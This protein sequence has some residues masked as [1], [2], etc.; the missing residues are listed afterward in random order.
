MLE[1]STLINWFA[2]YAYEPWMVYA[3][4]L[5]L[6][7]ASSFGLPLPEEVTL[8]SAGFLAYFSL[9]PELYPPPYEGA[10]SVRV[11]SLAAFCFF[12]VMFSDLLVF[13]IGKFGGTRVFQSKMLQ[14]YVTTEAFQKVF[15]WTSQ[16]GAWM[17]GLF[18]F[19]PGLRFPGH[20][21]CGALGVPVWKFLLIDGT[22]ALLTVPTQILLVAY[23]GDIVLENIKHFKILIAILIALSLLI[24][25]MRK[26][27]RV[28]AWF[29]K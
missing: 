14:Q 8:I 4:I 13:S 6:L 5:T 22:A 3:T 21:A 16:N 28:R 17:S 27:P 7:T 10:Q 12:A 23:Y 25:F 11:I 2:S 26:H 29:K 18:R 19:T 1:Q 24:Y 15:K 9:H 20:M